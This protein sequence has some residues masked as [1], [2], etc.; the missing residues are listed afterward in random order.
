[1]SMLVR[2]LGNEVDLAHD[3]LEAIQVAERFRPELVLM[4]LGMPKLNG[5]EAAKRI[6]AE[7]WGTDM[8]LVATTGW[9][10]EEDRRRTKDAGFD[11]HLV[12]PVEAAKL[13]ELLAGLESQRP[14][15]RQRLRSGDTQPDMLASFAMNAGSVTGAASTGGGE[16]GQ[17]AVPK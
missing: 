2:V 13:Q 12:K 7:S 9:G 8:V 5:Y 1:M 15:D 4:D 11:H 6:R 14:A 16:F 17:K 3:G 10:Q